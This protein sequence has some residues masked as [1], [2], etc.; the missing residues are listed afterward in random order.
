MRPPS[1]T[2]VHVSVGWSA[3]F[4]PASRP[5]VPSAPPSLP[6]DQSLDHSPRLPPSSRVSLLAVHAGEASP[7]DQ[8]RDAGVEAAELGDAHRRRLLLLAGCRF[9]VQPTR[10]HVCLRKHGERRHQPLV[11]ER[12]TGDSPHHHSE[13]EKA[14][15]NAPARGRERSFWSGSTDQMALRI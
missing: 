11:T 5:A 13:N 7:S 4:R 6:I 3:R 9:R 10:L 15:H 8:L 1:P 14:R 12:R 2:P